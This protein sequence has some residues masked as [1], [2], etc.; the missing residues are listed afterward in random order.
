MGPGSRIP[1]RY[2]DR[3]FLAP[4]DHLHQFSGQLSGIDI[5]GCDTAEPPA[6]LQ[7]IIDQHH[8]HAFGRELA[9]QALHL[10]A[11]GIRSGQEAVQLT[12]PFLI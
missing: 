3:P 6:I 7:I 9:Q 8:R 5:I 11:V 4:K 1:C 10:K 12:A 2:Q